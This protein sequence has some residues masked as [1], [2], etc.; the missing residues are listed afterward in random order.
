MVY[1]DSKLITSIPQLTIKKRRNR[2]SIKKDTC[3]VS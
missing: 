2:R 1:G 3:S